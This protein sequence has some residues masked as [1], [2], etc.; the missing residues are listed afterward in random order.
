MWG[1]SLTAYGRLLQPFYSDGLFFF[2]LFSILQ[3]AP[4]IKLLIGYNINRY[5]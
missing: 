3:F 1:N 5:Q 4:F 2:Y